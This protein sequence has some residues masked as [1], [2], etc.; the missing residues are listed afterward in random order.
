[1]ADAGDEDSLRTALDMLVEL[2]AAPLATRVRH[3]LREMGT[4]GIPAGPRGSTVSH[5]AGL[6]TRQAEVLDLLGEGLTD[7]E[8]AERLYISPKT[9]GHHVSAILRK[10]DV[11]NRTEAIV[12][13]ADNAI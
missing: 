3:R 11:R 12:W 4:T 6:T 7:R 9:V 1:M 2:G 10:L 13:A 5:P 8:I